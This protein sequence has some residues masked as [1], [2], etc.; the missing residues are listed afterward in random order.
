MLALR[1]LWLAVITQAVSHKTEWI[2]TSL[3][4]PKH[5]LSATVTWW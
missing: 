3:S 4:G 1:E 5:D 2:R